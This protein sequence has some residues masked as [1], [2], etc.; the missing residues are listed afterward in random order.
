MVAKGLKTWFKTQD[1]CDFSRLQSTTMDMWDPFINVVKNSFQDAENFIPFD[2]FHVSQH[3]GKALEKVRAEEH[4]V[5]MA[6]ET[7][8]PLVRSKYQ[9]LTNYH[10]VDNRPLR[11]K[12]FMQLNRCNLKTARAWQSKEAAGFLWNYS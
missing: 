9:W 8:S 2:R 1:K 4:R 11:G 6:G 3:F 12:D 5:F 7:R 10:R